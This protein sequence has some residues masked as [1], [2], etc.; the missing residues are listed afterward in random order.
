[1]TEREGTLIASGQTL[2]IVVARFNHFVTERLLEGAL[3]AFERH[4]GDPKQVDVVRVPGA[5]ELPLAVK[6]LAAS[7][8]YQ[9]VV[10]LA[11]VIRGATPHFDYVSSS[12]TSG[13]SSVMLETGIPVG[14]GVLTTDTV[15]QAIDRAGAK[16][17]NKGADALMTVV[18]MVNLLK[19]LS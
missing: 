19:V 13:L 18:E 6:A 9:G 10:A 1:M 11:A 14:F 15:E 2:A 4:G 5:F 3:D 17:G 8:R 12:A 16:S 7:G